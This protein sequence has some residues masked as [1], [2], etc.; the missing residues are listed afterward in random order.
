ML[1]LHN[2]TN[3]D[4]QHNNYL[5]PCQ[6]LLFHRYVFRP[7]HPLLQKFQLM[8]YLFNCRLHIRLRSLKHQ[9]SNLKTSSLILPHKTKIETTYSE[10]AFA[11]A[12]I[13]STLANLSLNSS[14]F[15]TNFHPTQYFH[16]QPLALPLSPITVASKICS[17]S[18][19]SLASTHPLNTTNL[20]NPMNFNSPIKQTDSQLLSYGDFP[21]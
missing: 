7:T 6:T 18:N 4:N 14:L 21:K 8:L 2:I 13:T 11:Y 3:I 12:N 1:C 15:R 20:N 19:S 17:L 10:T 5:H 16:H 9:F